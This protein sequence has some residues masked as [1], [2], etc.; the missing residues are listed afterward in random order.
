MSTCSRQL[1]TLPRSSWSRSR[2]VNVSSIPRRFG[3]LWTT[4]A[5][6]SQ[7]SIARAA[8]HRCVQ[9]RLERGVAFLGRGKRVLEARGEVPNAFGGG[10][11]LRLGRPR[12]FRDAPLQAV[13]GQLRHVCN[14][15]GDVLLR[16]PGELLDG[17]LELAR[18]AL[19]GL[20]AR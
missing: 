6:K 16:L 13:G 4:P 7:C 11:V 14:P 10:V 12:H 8:A 2:V 5:A 3:L 17:L 18:Q 19:G 1:S 9:L 20:L 15:V